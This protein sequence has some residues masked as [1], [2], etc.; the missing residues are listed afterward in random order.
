MK[1]IVC[2]RAKDIE[3]MVSLIDKV[4]G[5]KNISEFL[6]LKSSPNNLDSNS[7]FVRN[8]DLPLLSTLPRITNVD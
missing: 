4:G 8:S 6:N 1:L 5:M 3:Q 2:G 7:S